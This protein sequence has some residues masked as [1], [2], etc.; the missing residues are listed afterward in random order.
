MTKKTHTPELLV[1][2]RT[3]APFLASKVMYGHNDSINCDYISVWDPLIQIAPKISTDVLR[4]SHN[5][6]I[7]GRYHPGLGYTPWS[8][9][10]S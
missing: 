10:L 1:F 2:H 3:W 6:G 9:L 5:C 4:F 8:I 7:A